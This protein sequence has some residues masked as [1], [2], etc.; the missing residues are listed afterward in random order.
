MNVMQALH[1]A[2]VHSGQEGLIVEKVK[3]L[4]S[5]G[6]LKLNAASGKSTRL[7]EKKKEL[8]L[9]RGQP[10]MLL[11]KCTVLKDATNS[12]VAGTSGTFKSL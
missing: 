5:S 10:F 7:A 9:A 3:Q 11:S 1:V 6:Q 12:K 4:R 2:L 8:P